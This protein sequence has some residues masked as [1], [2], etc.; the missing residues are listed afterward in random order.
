MNR[1]ELLAH[2]DLAAKIDQMEYRRN[3]GT[4]SGLLDRPGTISQRPRRC[5]VPR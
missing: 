5:P 3:H 1:D 4:K 2:E